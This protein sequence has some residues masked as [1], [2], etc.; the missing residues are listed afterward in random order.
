ML[1]SGMVMIALPRAIAAHYTDQVD[2]ATLAATLIPI[3]GVFQVFDGIQ[4]VS[5]GV[6]R[7]LGDTRAPFVIN[8]AGFWLIGFPVSIAL[9]F[10]S[11]LGAV[12][13]WWG[14]VAG[15]VVVAAL[16]V[17]RVRHRMRGRL[18]PTTLGRLV[19]G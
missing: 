3:A 4:A 13:L 5:A 17:G 8:L 6:L 19:Q 16:L 2:V 15:L 7:G 14:L 10:H 12:G 11:T 1:C 18:D 9:G